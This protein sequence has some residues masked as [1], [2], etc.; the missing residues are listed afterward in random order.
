MHRYLEAIPD[1]GGVVDYS[2][3][4]FARANDV[5]NSP[6]ASRLEVRRHFGDRWI[7][8]N[9]LGWRGSDMNAL[10]EVRVK[11]VE[12]LSTSASAFVG[13]GNPFMYEVKLTG[14]EDEDNTWG[15]VMFIEREPS[16]ISIDTNRGNLRR[17]PSGNINYRRREE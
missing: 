1:W 2:K 9:S 3:T 6:H 14:D 4:K 17:T 11:P 10:V 7:S 8:I 16:I 15:R 13:F 5:G 12:E